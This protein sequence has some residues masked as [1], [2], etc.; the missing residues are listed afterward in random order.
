MLILLF[1][2]V[3][4]QLGNKMEEGTFHANHPFV[5]Y[6]EDETTSTI[7]YIGK[8]K[9][10]LNTSGTTGKVKEL[11]LRINQDLSTTTSGKQS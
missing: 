8:V 10:P 2:N 9:D 5:F 1:L 7:L 4:V 11:P 3:E 6:I